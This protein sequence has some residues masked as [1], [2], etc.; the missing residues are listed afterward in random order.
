MANRVLQ[1][2]IPKYLSK[3]TDAGSFFFHIANFLP[4]FPFFI[5]NGI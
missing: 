3:I 4:I 1:A 2:W 5:W